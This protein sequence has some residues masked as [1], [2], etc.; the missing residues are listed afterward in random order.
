MLSIV[1]AGKIVVSI[2]I[3]LKNAMSSF[4]RIYLWEEI[5]SDRTII[6]R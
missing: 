3:S 5:Q 6:I 4:T 2:E 1:G